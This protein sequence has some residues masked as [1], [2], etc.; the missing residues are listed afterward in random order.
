MEERK[1]TLA[2]LQALMDRQDG[3]AVAMLVADDATVI[4]KIVELIEGPRRQVKVINRLMAAV[5]QDHAAVAAD[6]RSRWLLGIEDDQTLFDLGRTCISLESALEKLL[7][8]RYVIVSSLVYV[9]AGGTGDWVAAAETLKVDVEQLRSWAKSSLHD[10]LPG[11][12]PQYGVVENRRNSGDIRAA[13]AMED[14]RQ[15]AKSTVAM[16]V[17]AGEDLTE[18]MTGWY[19]EAKHRAW[20]AKEISSALVGFEGV[21]AGW[22]KET[23]AQAMATAKVSR[24]VST[25]ASGEIAEAIEEAGTLARRAEAIE[26]LGAAIPKLKKRLRTVRQKAFR[27]MFDSGMSWAAVAADQRIEVSTARQLGANGLSPTD[28]KKR[29]RMNR[30]KKADHAEQRR[31]Q[32]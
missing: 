22:K 24:S 2:D 25:L 5:V 17:V 16:L 11:F 4:D 20:A 9:A 18:V 10:L 12:V 23:A 27:E 26:A 15:R 13:L 8:A 32:K 1:L 28:K 14:P 30:R 6:C 7:H 19:P 29:N 21:I 3:R 31:E